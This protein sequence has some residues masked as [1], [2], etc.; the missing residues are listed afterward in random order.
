MSYGFNRFLE[1]RRFV[2]LLFEW[3]L[4]NAKDDSVLHIVVNTEEVLE[5]LRPASKDGSIARVE[6][7]EWAHTLPLEPRRY[8]YFIRDKY[9][10]W[11]STPVGPTTRY[12]FL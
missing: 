12:V 6:P 4:R 7:E 2:R 9:I 3:K 8:L 11:S 10:A 1:G 5:V